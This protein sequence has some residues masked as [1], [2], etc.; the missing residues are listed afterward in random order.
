MA[1]SDW[2]FKVELPSNYDKYPWLVE[3]YGEV[4]SVGV[5]A[6]HEVGQQGCLWKISG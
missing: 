1:L 4:K 2:K 5:L 3:A 6:F